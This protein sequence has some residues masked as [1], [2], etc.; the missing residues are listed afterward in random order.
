MDLNKRFCSPIISKEDKIKIL[1]AVFSEVLEPTVIVFVN[2]LIQRN[3]FEFLERIY[4]ALMNIIDEK[5]GLVRGDVRLAKRVDKKRQDEIIR[6]LSN[7][8]GK[9]LQVNFI[10]DTSLIAG[11]NTMIGNYYIDYS[12]KGQLE[13]LEIELKRS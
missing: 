7:L 2:L 11:F 6:S 10:Q 12:L 5:T 4:K 8:T 1:E 9:K 3:R 13:Q